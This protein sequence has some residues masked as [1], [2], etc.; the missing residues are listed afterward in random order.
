MA[1]NK[2]INRGKAKDSKFPAKKPG[3]SEEKSKGRKA[4]MP[5][6]KK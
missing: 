5:K 4:L 3:L 2:P 6:K 1:F